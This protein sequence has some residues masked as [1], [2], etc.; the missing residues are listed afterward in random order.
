MPGIVSVPTNR[1]NKQPREKAKP[2]SSSPRP[3]NSKHLGVKRL[4]LQ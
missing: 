2:V 3:M 1:Q 4:Y